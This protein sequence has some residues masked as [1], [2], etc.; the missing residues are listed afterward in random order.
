MHLQNNDKCFTVY[1]LN[2]V[3]TLSVLIYYCPSG[4]IKVKNI[5]K[6]YSIFHH[7]QI[8]Y[9]THVYKKTVKR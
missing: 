5:L 2:N 3:L 7:F 4:I 6:V 9:F 1:T 8:D